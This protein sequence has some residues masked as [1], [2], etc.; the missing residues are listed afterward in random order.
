[1]SVPKSQRS[2]AR[3]KVHTDIRKLI[4]HTLTKT[5]NGR[6]FGGMARYV[7]ERDQ[8]GR[9]TAIE[10]HRTASRSALAD[11]LDEA[12]IAA[13]ECAWRANDIKICE[14]YAERRRLQDEA[15]RNL[16]ALIWLIEV[17][18]LSC[19]LSPREARHWSDMARSAR[20]ITRKWRDSDARRH[21]SSRDE[22]L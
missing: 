6:K 22:G 7:I 21:R 15:I 12:A 2:E 9:V 13:G 20:A 10:E 17:A 18:R 5:R 1:M 8:D 19:N 11:R 14:G 3:L 16:D 4:D